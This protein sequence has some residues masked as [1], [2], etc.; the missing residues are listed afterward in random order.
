MVNKKTKLFKTEIPTVEIL[1]SCPDGIP[2]ALG[3]AFLIHND[4]KFVF[5]PIENIAYLQKLV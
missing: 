1:K 5:S 2:S 3:N 4:L